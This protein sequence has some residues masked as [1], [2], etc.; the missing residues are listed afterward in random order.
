MIEIVHA[1]CSSE[2]VKFIFLCDVAL[3]DLWPHGRKQ[4]F[5]I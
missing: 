1:V 5:M 4:Y 2:K 3:V